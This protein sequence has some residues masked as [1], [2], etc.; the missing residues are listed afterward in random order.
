MYLP[1]LALFAWG[2]IF[3]AEIS[4]LLNYYYFPADFEFYMS[5]IK[6]KYECKKFIAFVSS[7]CLPFKPKSN[8]HFQVTTYL[9]QDTKIT[10][11]CAQIK[12]I[13][14]VFFWQSKK[15]TF[16]IKWASLCFGIGNFFLF[17]FPKIVNYFK[18]NG[19]TKK[20]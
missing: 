9:L 1:K 11:R 8:W 20:S 4:P 12:L 10:F 17:F 7:D 18:L 6:L 3:A 19:F 2:M 14:S 5:I 13:V 15:N 16:W